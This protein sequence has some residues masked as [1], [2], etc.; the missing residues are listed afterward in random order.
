MK[1][2]WNVI[3]ILAFA[4]VL[5]M[6][7][8]VGW[9]LNSG[10]LNADRAE[11]IQAIFSETVAEQTAREIAERQ[12]ADAEAEQ[13]RSEAVLAA[14]PVTAS[15][16][17]AVRLE[18]SELDR[19]R[20]ERLRREVEDLQRSVRRERQ[21]LDEAVATFEKERTEFQE[22]REQIAER[23]GDAQFQKAVITY[24][25]MK[26]K[27]TAAA[28]R[29]LIDGGEPDRVVDYLN[30]MEDRSR[31]KIMTEITK[32]EPALAAQLLEALS[33]RGV[34]ARMLE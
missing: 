2:V 22:M 17:L 14:P 32:D 24:E 10:R 29:E 8:V 18:A 23:E 1:T 13:A 7:A 19:Q 9:L 15:E 6:G 5:A 26:A 27:E 20:I 16:A 12:Q 34:E 3:A 4:H 31:V 30:A 33:V 11:Q 28:F 25:G 21:L